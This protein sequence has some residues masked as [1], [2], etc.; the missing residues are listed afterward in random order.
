MD[1]DAKE[2]LYQLFSL[3]LETLR[4]MLLQSDDVSYHRQIQRIKVLLENYYPEDLNLNYQK[5]LDVLSKANLSPSLPDASESLKLLERI[6]SE[7][8]ISKNTSIEK[9]Q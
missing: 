6:M 3:R 5:Q 1:I 9:G 4:I 2:R 8:S 7:S